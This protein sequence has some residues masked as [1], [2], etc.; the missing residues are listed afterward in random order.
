MFGILKQLKLNNSSIQL[1][2]YGELK[3]KNLFE[4]CGAE[5]RNY[6]TNVN[7]FKWQN[8]ING[9]QIAHN[10]IKIGQLLMHKIYEEILNDKPD[11]IIY[12]KSALYM[13]YGPYHYENETSIIFTF[14]QFQPRSHFRDKNKFKFVGSSFNETIRFNGSNSLIEIE[15]KIKA[16]ISTGDA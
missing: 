14:P 15:L 11:L 5:F 10:G 7:I 1:I 12:D 2:V 13:V 16:I 4:T 8:D 6:E 9:F 3:F